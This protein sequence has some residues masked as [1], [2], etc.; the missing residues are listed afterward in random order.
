MELPMPQKEPLV[1]PFEANR[2]EWARRELTRHPFG[3]LKVTAP[4]K[5]G[6]LIE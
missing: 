6:F 2:D 3:R 4:Q 5:I 1:S